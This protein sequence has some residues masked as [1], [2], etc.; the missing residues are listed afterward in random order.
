MQDWKSYWFLLAG[1]QGLLLTI[2]LAARS[3]RN[4]GVL[5]YLAILIG[6]LSIELLTNFAVS[7]N[8][9]NHADAFPFWLL[10]SYLF[11]PPSL[12][13][14][15]RNSI[16]IKPLTLQQST[17]LFIPAF[18]E[19][20][21][22]T[23][24]FFFRSAG[25][26][27]P[28]LQKNIPW[29]AFT[30]IVPVTATLIILG[31][32]TIRLWRKPFS[33]KIYSGK[34]LI[35][36][37]ALIPLALPFYYLLLGILWL[38]DAFFGWRFSDLLA[39]LLAGSMLLLGYLVLL[40]SGLFDRLSLVSVS[41]PAAPPAAWAYDDRQTVERLLQLMEQ[42]KMFIQ[43]RLSVDD[44][45]TALNIPRRYLTHILATQLNTTA[46]AFINKYRVEDLLRKMKD[47]ELQSKTILALAME[48]G[49]SSK[50]TFN[51]VFKNHTG[52]TP[53]EYL[54]NKC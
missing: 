4:N 27:V 25:T 2:G 20:F 12:Y 18:I 7:I 45:A 46:I 35:F 49:F 52:M 6:I 10:G 1:G 36:S 44:L 17:L 38:S 26:S 9:P 13:S 5:I 34:R 30:E 19:V 32:W 54:K 48:S 41:T 43:S 28:D 42:Q 11:I 29:F 16:G 22:E 51:Q 23:V 53:S 8:Y 31:W 39:Q 3:K 47:D 50:S 15:A 21:A 24:V 40:R 37:A 33:T 14:L